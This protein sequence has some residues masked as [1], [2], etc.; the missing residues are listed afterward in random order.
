[1]GGE[2]GRQSAPRVFLGE[3][4]VG[5]VLAARD[6]VFMV[7]ESPLPGHNPFAWPFL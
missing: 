1:M 4:R 5:C 6:F 2:R 7:F 3:L